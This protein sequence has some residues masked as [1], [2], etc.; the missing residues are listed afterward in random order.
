M[1]QYA[2][3]SY[4]FPPGIIINLIRSLS[5]SHVN[6]LTYSLQCVSMVLMHLKYLCLTIIKLPTVMHAHC[7]DTCIVSPSSNAV[8]PLQE[9]NPPYSPVAFEMQ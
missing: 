3:Y 5:F 2:I 8:M 7:G 6:S 9:L 4:K 1:V